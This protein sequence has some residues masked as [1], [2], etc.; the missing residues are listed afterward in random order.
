MKLRERCFV[1]LL[2]PVLLVLGSVS[3]QAQEWSGEQK[4][5]WK[6]VTMYWD[7]FANGDAQGMMNY[8][9]KDYSG[10]DVNDPL[11]SDRASTAKGVEHFLS[12]NSI[13]LYEI[14]PTAINVYEKFAT[15]HYYY[16]MIVKNSEGKEFTTK[17]RWTDILIQDDGKWYLIGDHGGRTSN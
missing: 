9:H 2:V 8:F 1:T 12:N 13:V 11:P 6:N 15:V 5:V 10:W 16:Q 3:V 14:K 17:G 4:K 7:L